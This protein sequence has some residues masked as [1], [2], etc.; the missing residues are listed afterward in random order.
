MTATGIAGDAAGTYDAADSFGSVVR[1]RHPVNVPLSN[2]ATKLHPGALVLAQGDVGVGNPLPLAH[3]STADWTQDTGLLTN[4][5]TDW[6]DCLT[7]HVAHGASTLMTGYASVAN[8]AD[9]Q[10][11]TGY[12]DI[13]G[14]GL[15]DEGA[16]GVAPAY[17]NALL[18]ANNRTVCEVCH[19]K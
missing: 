5:T 6:I 17:S 2:F 19:N 12:E 16:G 8:P 14:D 10:P 9:P 15:A 1:H 11:G 3:D 4:D 18:R 13:D 7:C